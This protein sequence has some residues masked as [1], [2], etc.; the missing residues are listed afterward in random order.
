MKAYLELYPDAPDAR[1][2]KDEIYRWEIQME[3]ERK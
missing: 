2:A 3:K 1:A